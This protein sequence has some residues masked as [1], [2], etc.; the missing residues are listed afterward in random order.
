MF[1]FAGF[2][3]LV[4]FL[5]RVLPKPSRAAY[6]CQRA[7]FPLA[8]AFVLWVAGLAG[9]TVAWTQARRLWRRSRFAMAGI[10]L[11]AAGAAGTIALLPA[12]AARGVDESPLAPLGQ[13][14]GAHPG[15]VVW[16]HNPDATDWRGPGHGHWWQAVHTDQKAV[17]RMLDRAIRDLAGESTTRAA[18]DRLFRSF[19]LR[20][21]RGD[22]GYEPGEKI[23]IKVNFV[24][25]I[26]HR[27]WGGV[28]PVTHDLVDKL[29]Y[30]NTAP[31]VI[32]ALLRQLVYVAGVDPADIAVGDTLAYYPN[33]YLRPCRAEFPEVSYLDY[34]GGPGRVAV[35]RSSVPL[36]WS[37]G[38]EGVLQDYVPASYAEAAYLINVA[39]LKS[40]NSNAG[41]TLTAK[42][43][44]GSLIRWPV[45]TGYFDLHADLPA[46]R[47][48]RGRYRP[49]VD[50]M[51]HPDLGEKTVLF[52]IDGLY[53][54]R[55]TA[56]NVPL[57]WHLPPF[58]GDWTSSLFASQDGVAI[59]SVG[60]DFLRA[61]WSGAPHLPG[62]DD[63]LHEAALAHDP[64]SGTFYDPAHA[65]DVD[66]LASLGVH[67]HWND[68]K[69]KQ[70]SRNLGEDDG[71]GLLARLPE[72][73]VSIGL[74]EVD[75]VRGLERRE[76]A[77]S[78][79]EPDR[80]GGR[81][82]RRNRGN[83]RHVYFAVDDGF[84]FRGD[85]VE[86]Y[87]TIDYFDTGSGSLRL[88]YDS[89]AGGALEA[90]YKDGGEVTLHGS[91]RW[92]RHTFHLV[93]AFFGNRQ[94][95]GADF[96][97]TKTGVAEPFYLAAVEVSTAP[98]PSAVSLDAGTVDFPAGLERRE[99][100][101]SE[102]VADR[103]G[104]RDCRRSLDM[105]SSSPDRHMYFAVDDRFAYRGNRPEVAV[106]VHY[107]DR[108]SGALRLR[109]D[110]AAGGSEAARFQD[111]GTVELG[112]SGTWKQH[113]FHLTDA[114]FG[115]RQI[116]G[117]D[118][119]VS[120]TGPAE[121][122]YLDVVEISAENPN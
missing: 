39:N 108:G 117:A 103:V 36:Y 115:N 16:V 27:F 65:G 95:R 63:Y 34:A 111:G 56:E 80:I 1:P 45:E 35:R 86:L 25:A 60:L 9:S 91:G 114:F 48:G 42:N 87:V 59:D 105:T 52:L 109:Y 107:F 2:L 50:L 41:V 61:E 74:G 69:R 92:R 5:V 7:A 98:M 83:D 32:L 13:G 43:H 73:A 3:A 19:N 15:R 79:T 6:P 4:W 12:G 57:R 31:Q 38:G 8:S 22:A 28:D 116:A 58:T 67:E 49:L 46:T 53:A 10:L 78:E 47:P 104:G 68:E 101:A 17:D 54:G 97:I 112:D 93:D 70:Y 100:A 75:R 110:S 90:R 77:A 102:T 55:H 26:F 89:T 40:H 113:T 30:M 76:N 24:G 119:R 37:R 88:A 84:A 120:K 64:P 33:Q 118:F 121:P 21:G 11:A 20:R 99:N 82:C 85:S 51:G 81:S 66:R 71:I 44:F 96:R 29:D 122:F 106:T 14:R 23:T 18:W 94:N 62:T 72:R